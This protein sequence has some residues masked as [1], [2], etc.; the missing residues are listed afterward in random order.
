LLHKSNQNNSDRRRWAFLVAYNKRSNN[1]VK[2]HHHPQYTKLHKVDDDAILG[3]A[4]ASDMT[5]K[6]FLNPENDETVAINKHK[7]H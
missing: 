1:P 6:D 5:G 3:C 2:K 4:N 7:I